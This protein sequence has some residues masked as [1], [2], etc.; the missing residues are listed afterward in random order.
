MTT[1]EA[2]VSICLIGWI[3]GV[4]FGFFMGLWFCLKSTYAK[5][6][7]AQAIRESMEEEG[8]EFVRK[9]TQLMAEGPGE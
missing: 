8:I 4:G 9:T 5:R 2:S 7:L 1:Q 3:L 6:A